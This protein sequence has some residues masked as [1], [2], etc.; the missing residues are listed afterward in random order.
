[1]TQDNDRMR[2][3]Q[4][5][6]GTQLIALVNE[7]FDMGMTDAIWDW[8]YHVH[9]KGTG[10]ISVAESNDEL[11]A[12]YA[13]MRQHL[14]HIGNEI[15]AAQSADTAVRKDQRRKGWML[16]LGKDVIARAER[17][18][19]EAIHGFPNRNISPWVLL[20]FDYHR[21]CNLKFYGKNLGKR[22]PLGPLVNWP[23]HIVSLILTN[24][25]FALNKRMTLPGSVFTHET[26]LDEK[27]ADEMVKE[28][29][30]YEIISIWKDGEYLK[31]RYQDHPFN[32]YEYFTLRVNGRLEGLV[33][34]R[35]D[36]KRI[37]ICEFINR[38]KDNQQSFMTLLYLIKHFMGRGF[39]ELYFQG[40][41]DGYFD[42]VF[43][44]AGFEKSNTGLIYACMRFKHDTIREKTLIP[45]N[46]TLVYGD[47]DLI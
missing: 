3:Y 34:T 4:Q 45:Q 35:I 7:V 43:G 32:S 19:A 31:W 10:W 40:H 11:V 9:P 18:G 26:V 23:L 8:K 46:W 44:M 47:S 6:D 25:R 36:G 12:H 38:T 13:L 42:T 14:N 15:P 1:M 29:N 41:D 5:A 37:A 28:Y 24:I 39:R 20:N 17:E 30:R 22:L 21:V 27:E 16:R 33:V 2:P